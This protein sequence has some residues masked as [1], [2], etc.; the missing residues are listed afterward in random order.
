MKHVIAMDRLDE[1]AKAFP[2]GA[3]C[4]VV[5]A[6]KVGIYPPWRDFSPRTVEADQS[7]DGYFYIKVVHTGRMWIEGRTFFP[8]CVKN[9]ESHVY[10]DVQYRSIVQNVSSPGEEFKYFEPL[11]KDYANLMDTK[12]LVD[13][14]EPFIMDAKGN[15]FKVNSGQYKVEGF[16]YQLTNTME[17]AVLYLRRG[18]TDDYFCCTLSNLANLEKED[19]TE[20]REVIASWFSKELGLNIVWDER[21]GSYTIKTYR[22]RSS[23]GDFKAGPFATVKQAEEALEKIKE[24]SK[25]TFKILQGGDVDSLKV[26]E[27]SDYDLDRY[28]LD[29]L[30]ELAEEAGVKVSMKDILSKKKGQIQA[31]KIGLLD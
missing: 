1:M 2:K 25:D 22:V 21:R 13:G 9:M 14:D 10:S 3:I 20:S 29:Q 6:S 28:S 5:N 19:S 30:K 26:D 11:M 18:S 15:T 23:Q 7:K 17:E 12:G 16:N 4:K 8:N 31:K 27:T 24:I